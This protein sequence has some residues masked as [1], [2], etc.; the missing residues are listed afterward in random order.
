MI[1]HK[2]SSL[3]LSREQCSSVSK[4]YKSLIFGCVRHKTFET[5]KFE[6]VVLQSCPFYE[7]RGKEKVK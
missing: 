4:Q 2:S 5:K 3:F 6:E 7:N 1:T